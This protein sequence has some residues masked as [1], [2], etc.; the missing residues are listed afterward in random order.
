MFISQRLAGFGAVAIVGLGGALV[1]G[2]APA[3]AASVDTSYTC[4]TI[5]GPSMSAVKVK[6][7]LPD[8]AKA[9]ST[10]PSRKFKMDIALPEELVGTLNFFGIKSLAGDVSKLSYKVGKTKVAVTGAKIPTTAVPATGAM[11]LKVKG[12]SAAFKAPAAGKHVVKVPTTYTMT[13][14]SNG[15]TLDTPTCVRDKASASKLGTLTTTK[16]R[17][18]ALGLRP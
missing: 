16:N 11:T 8:T 14:T 12:T 6:L 18:G 17:Q 15:G 2:V 10:V 3:Q 5:N 13:L 1:G 9:G 7:S 4:E